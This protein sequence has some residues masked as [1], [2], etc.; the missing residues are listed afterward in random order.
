MTTFRALALLGVLSL[1]AVP[2]RAQD[3]QVPSQE[4]MAVWMAYMTPGEAHQELAK[5]AGDWNHTLQMWMAPGAPAM[6]TTATSHGEMLLEGRYLV[7]QFQGNMMGMPFEGHA[8]T[9]YD[10]AKKQYFS[11][12]I[13]NMGTGIMI[14]WG[15]VDPA[16][17]TL[18]LTGTYVDP[19]DGQ[20][21]PFR[22]V[23]KRVD[24]NHHIMEMYMP[25]PDGSGEF[26]SM[27]IHS[28]RETS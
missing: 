23:M 22:Q 6:E 18:T 27:E 10:N 11:A 14:G 21:K 28:L 8:L 2:A 24:D 5:G 3:D 4:D 17:Q 7:E 25:A 13:D 9:G 19:A 15:A 26:K 1:L 16:T 20:E 12:W